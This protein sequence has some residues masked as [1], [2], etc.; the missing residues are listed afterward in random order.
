M[1]K[2]GGVQNA[3]TDAQLVQLDRER[4]FWRRAE[5]EYNYSVSIDDVSKLSAT[6]RILRQ[7]VPALAEALRADQ[8][9][10]FRPVLETLPYETTALIVVVCGL[11]VA[12]ATAHNRGAQGSSR[13][14]RSMDFAAKLAKAL[15]AEIGWRKAGEPEAADK[16][17]RERFPGALKG[18]VSKWAKKVAATA[19]DPFPTTRDEASFGRWIMAKMVD[20]SPDTFTVSRMFEGAQQAPTRIG[21]TEK[22]AK[23]LRAEADKVLLAGGRIPLRPF[24]YPMAIKPTRWSVGHAID[25]RLPDDRLPRDPQQGADPHGDVAEPADAGRSC[26]DQPDPRDTMADQSPRSRRHAALLAAARAFG[27]TDLGRT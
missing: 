11:R 16:G 14:A 10:L 26:G 2:Y 1:R 21:L 4:D 25:W 23:D 3:Y 6:Q 8:E 7:S 20:V 9:K 22:A 5:R 15:R 19:D 12:D 17:L 18:T 24:L 13:G 27:Q